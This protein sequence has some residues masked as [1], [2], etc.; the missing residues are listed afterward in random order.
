MSEL[1]DF[2]VLMGLMPLVFVGISFLYEV[3]IT[4]FFK[5]FSF[6]NPA[7]TCLKCSKEVSEYTLNSL[8]AECAIKYLLGDK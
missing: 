1:I 2:I 4:P 6:Q 3:F 8:C 7:L 5:L